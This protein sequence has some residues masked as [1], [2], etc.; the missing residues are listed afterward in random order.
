VS[1]SSYFAIDPVD[2]ALAYAKRPKQSVLVEVMH[3]NRA[4]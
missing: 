1:P 4:A 3:V 2:P